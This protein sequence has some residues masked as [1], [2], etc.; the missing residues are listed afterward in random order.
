MLIVTYTENTDEEPS[1]NGTLFLKIPNK[2]KRSQDLSFELAEDVDGDSLL[3]TSM[4]DDTSFSEASVDRKP[5]LG[6]TLSRRTNLPTSDD[7]QDSD[8][9]SSSMCSLE[10]RR[11]KN[12]QENK[13]FLKSLGITQMVEDMSNRLEE[14]K[15][16][17]R[18]KRPKVQVRY[19][20]QDDFL[21]YSFNRKYDSMLGPTWGA[22]K[23]LE[24]PNERTGASFSSLLPPQTSEP[25]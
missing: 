2:N 11:L 1:P 9:S 17:S 22:N 23:V 10:R 15:T 21:Q 25:L 12:I 19:W 13:E 16:V 5:V 20:S 7:S 3:S 8:S 14:K 4:D 6:E 24:L 18:A